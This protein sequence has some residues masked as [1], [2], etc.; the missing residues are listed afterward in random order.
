MQDGVFLRNAIDL[1]KEEK[2]KRVWEK[3]IIESREGCVGQLDSFAQMIQHATHEL[4]ASIFEDDF[5]TGAPCRTTT[6]AS[7]SVLSIAP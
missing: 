7:K 5:I 1:Y 3:R 6:A 2:Q 4:N